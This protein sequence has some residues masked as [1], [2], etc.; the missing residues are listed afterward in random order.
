MKKYITM[1]GGAAT[2][3]SLF[4]PF[5]EV[6][7][8]TVS[9]FKMGGA[10]WFY[11]ACGIAA[12]AAGYIDKRKLYIAAICTGLLIAALAMK[13]QSDLKTLQTSVGFGLWLLFF[14]G[15]ATLAGGIMGV[16]AKKRYVNK[17]EE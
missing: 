12:I 7:G 14:S 8:V 6:L 1:G 16:L 5:T 9:G 17:V 10:A 13:Y 15:L 2:V 4:L 3:V 11:I